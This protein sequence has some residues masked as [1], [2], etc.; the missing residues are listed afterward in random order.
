MQVAVG[1]V[2]SSSVRAYVEYA[3]QVLGDPAGPAADVPAEVLSAFR[4][5]LDEWRALA[6]SGSDVT[7]KA[8]MPLE[9]AEYLVHA[10]YR[11]AQRLEQRA[12]TIGRQSSPEIDA[13]YRCLVNGLLQGLATEGPSGAEFADHLR[14]FWPGYSTD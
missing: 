13:W 8:E 3:D 2:P 10:F 11:L 12:A 1:P 4:G 5:Y 6:A 14:T 7:W 9:M